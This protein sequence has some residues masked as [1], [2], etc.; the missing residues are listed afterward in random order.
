MP[1]PVYTDLFNEAIDDLTTKLQSISGLQVVNDP[2]NIVPPC[3]LINMPSFDAFNYNIAKLEFVLQVIT[4]GPGNLD[5]G[6]SLLNM[7]AQLMAA[8]VAVTSGRPTN[9]DIGSTVLPAY[10]IVVAMQ[11]Q[12][13]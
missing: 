13:G 12:T 7:C 5:A 4:L 9:V 2:R 8:N 3:V 1:V 6:R 11:A 10:E